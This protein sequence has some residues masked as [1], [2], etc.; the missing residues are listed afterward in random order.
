LELLEDD[1]EVLVALSETIGNL[2]DHVGGPAHAEHILRVLEKLAGIEELAV[3]EKVISV[4][5]VTNCRQ[6]KVLRKFLLPC[7]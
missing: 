6:P 5:F 2:L 4:L 3:R 1:E 7:A